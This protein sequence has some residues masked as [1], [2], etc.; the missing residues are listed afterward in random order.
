MAKTS[1]VVL[2]AR[3]ATGGAHGQ[4]GKPVP[5]GRWGSRRGGL[6]IGRHAG[7]LIGAAPRVHLPRGCLWRERDASRLTISLVSSSNCR[8]L[9]ESLGKASMSQKAEKPPDP[10]HEAKLAARREKHAAKVWAANPRSQELQRKYDA[11]L[12]QLQQL[13]DGTFCRQYRQMQQYCQRMKDERD[14]MEKARPLT[15]GF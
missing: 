5:A 12:Q 13:R 9:D 14:A 1:T 10:A 3:P 11:A 7:G 8:P 4:T 6:G 15:L 2:R